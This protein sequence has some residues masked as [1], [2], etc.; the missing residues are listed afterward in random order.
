[1]PSGKLTAIA[2]CS[3]MPGLLSTLIICI[4]EAI[5]IISPSVERAITCV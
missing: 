5:P 1:M 3:F 2:V 4:S